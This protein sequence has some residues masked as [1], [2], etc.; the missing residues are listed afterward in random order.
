MSLENVGSLGYGGERLTSVLPKALAEL[1]GLSIDLVAGAAN[2]TIAIT[3]M[4]IQDTLLKVLAFTAA[5]PVFADITSHVTIAS[6]NAKAVLTLNGVLAGDKVTVHSRVYTFVTATLSPSSGGQAP[7]SP[8]AGGA[9]DTEDIPVWVP[10]DTAS[11]ANLVALINANDSSVFASS[12]SGVVTI[13]AR[14]EG[15]G[16]N[17]YTVSVAASNAH[18][19][20]AG[21]AVTFL[22]GTASSGIVVDETTANMQLMVFWYKKPR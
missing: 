19:T 4:D 5:T 2:G 12:S 6:L 17:A 9:Y 1:Q 16:P 22:G 20:S 15:T 7:Y 8:V 10:D 21:S 3:G 18:V 13:V 11:A 14:T